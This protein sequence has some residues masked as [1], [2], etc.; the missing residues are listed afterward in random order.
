MIDDT[1]RG[2]EKIGVISSHTNAP[3]NWGLY[4]E[5]HKVKYGILYDEIL[6]KN[7]S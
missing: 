4:K 3:E 7:V 6:S 1:G 5:D 2:P